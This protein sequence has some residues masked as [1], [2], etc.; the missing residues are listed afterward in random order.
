MRV[1]LGGDFYGGRGVDS[2]IQDTS[3]TIIDHKIL[4]KFKSADL[5]ILNLESPL[6]SSNNPIKKSG[7]AIKASTEIG[8]YIKKWGINLV[9]LANNHILDFGDVGLQDTL[10]TL[11]KI[12]LPYVGA[13]LDI[14]RAK[15][16]FIF[17][18]S[19]K[20]LAILN[21]C[22]NE[23]STTHGNYPGANPIDEIENYN[24]I[25][26]AKAQADY[27]LVI[28]HGG[29]EHY[30]LP[31][32]RMKK[33]YRFYAEIGADAV[34]GHHSHCT[35][36]YEIRNGVP[37]F[38][39]LGNFLFNNPAFKDKNW[40]KGML[41][42]LNFSQ[43]PCTFELTHFDQ[44]NDNKGVETVSAEVSNSRNKEIEALNEI[45]QSDS[46]LLESYHLWLISNQKKYKAFLE[47]HT[48]RYI[49]FLQTRKLL[50]SFWANRKRI[51]LLNL[52]RCEAHRDAVVHI[53]ENEINSKI[54]K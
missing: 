26:K 41:L 15:S 48:N 53:L 43:K 18:M 7:P 30:S 19:H 33:L 10:H 52:I 3:A 12:K 42:S 38:Y 9:N 4:T 21:F 49:Q 8:A 54:Y 14:E 39:S 36:G 23:W 32:P 46:K 11:D 24:Q 40:N 29:H 45:I 22:E 25:K 2:L 34:V 13:G 28:A 51:F 44:C 50:P 1:I 47:P 27:V 6:T 35:S 37:I 31:S 16:P 17:E 20:K 5:A